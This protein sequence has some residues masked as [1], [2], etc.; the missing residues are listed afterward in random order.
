[1]NKKKANSTQSTFQVGLLKLSSLG[2]DAQ[3]RF[4]MLKKS[5][6]VRFLRERQFWPSQKS[7]VHVYVCMRFTL[8]PVEWQA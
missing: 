4:N 2:I 6:C 8:M 5:V 1:M 3:K 7:Q